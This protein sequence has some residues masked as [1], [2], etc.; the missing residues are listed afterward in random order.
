[1]SKKKPTYEERVIAEAADII[2]QA[3][4]IASVRIA[5]RYERQLMTEVVTRIQTQLEANDEVNSYTGKVL[6]DKLNNLSQ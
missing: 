4:H 5:D 1:M 6:N 3:I 2:M